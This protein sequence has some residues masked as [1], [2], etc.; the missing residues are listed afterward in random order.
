[1]T[2]NPLHTPAMD[3]ETWWA[4]N[5]QQELDPKQLAR[6][7]WHAAQDVQREACARL[8]EGWEEG[9]YQTCGNGNYWDP[10]TIYNQGRID[11]AA[12]CRR[13]F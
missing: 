1:M 6:T 12:A 5:D 8:A 2:P 7:A 9:Q 4:Q 3:F 13:R 11:A 10:G